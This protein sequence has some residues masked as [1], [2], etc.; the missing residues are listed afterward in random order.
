LKELSKLLSQAEK[1][2]TNATKGVGPL[3]FTAT[4]IVMLLVI[5]IYFRGIKAYL[6]ETG[7]LLSADEFDRLDDL[8]FINSRTDEEEKEFKALKAKKKKL[9]EESVLTY[10][11]GG[12]V[13][14][15]LAALALVRMDLLVMWLK[16]F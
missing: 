13:L 11:I 1:T 2:I 16:Q 8:A 14:L 3:L 10:Y 15:L 7:R 12:G 4:A 6:R 9:G 5:F